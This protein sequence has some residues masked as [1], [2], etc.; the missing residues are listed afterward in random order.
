MSILRFSD[1]VEIDTSGDLRIIELADGLYV[2]G[3]GLSVPVANMSEAQSVLK[4][5]QM[6]EQFAAMLQAK[7]STHH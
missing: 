1:G 7:V 4:H 3:R 5:E 2:I 6:H